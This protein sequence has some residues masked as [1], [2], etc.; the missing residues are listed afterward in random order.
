MADFKSKVSGHV[1]VCKMISMLPLFL[2]KIF[3]LDFGTVLMEW[4]FLLFI[5]CY[6]ICS[7]MLIVVFLYK[8][9]SAL[10]ILDFK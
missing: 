2:H 1:Y 3:H 6:I 4:Y 9:S 10:F 7:T 8:G 5:L